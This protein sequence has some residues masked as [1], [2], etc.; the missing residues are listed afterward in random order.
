[1]IRLDELPRQCV[2]AGLERVIAA[3]GQP[4]RGMTA[5]GLIEGLVRATRG[6]T[7]HEFEIAVDA[8]ISIE[9]YW[10]GI[11]A[12]VKHRPLPA[13]IASA[14]REEGPDVCRA[15]GVHYH[16]RGFTTPTGKVEPRLRCAC[17]RPEAGWN[18]PEALA[19]VE[20]DPKVIGTPFDAEYADGGQPMRRAA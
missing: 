2:S 9:T 20:D 13:S 16:Y 5:P 18:T 17:D 3:R 4:P 11:P 14:P 1:M 10:P 15:C 12:I 8:A 7:Q 19:W 6:W